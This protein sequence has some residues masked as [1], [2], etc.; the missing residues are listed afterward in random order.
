MFFVRFKFFILISTDADLT[1]KHA[2]FDDVGSKGQAS[3]PTMAAQQQEQQ[4][5]MR[6]YVLACGCRRSLMLSCFGEGS[7]VIWSSPCSPTS[8]RPDPSK[9]PLTLFFYY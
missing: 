9:L 5:A 3:N 4:L 6:N 7:I 8:S 2:T 1:M